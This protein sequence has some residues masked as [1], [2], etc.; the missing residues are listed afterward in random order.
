MIKL[1]GAH[2]AAMEKLKAALVI[3]VF[4]PKVLHDKVE[5]AAEVWKDSS[6]RGKPHSD[7]CSSTTARLRAFLGAIHEAL[8]ST[9]PLLTAPVEAKEALALLVEKVRK[10]KAEELISDDTLR[11]A[12]SRTADQSP[13]GMTLGVLGKRPQPSRSASRARPPLTPGTCRRKHGRSELTVLAVVEDSGGLFVLSDTC[14]SGLRQRP[15]QGVLSFHSFG[16]GAASRT[17]CAVLQLFTTF[18]WRS[19]TCSS[20]ARLFGA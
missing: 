13:Y 1:S 7:G 10:G 15:T 6:E 9:V 11:I 8:S 17:S 18:C 19:P 4:L 12:G 3:L 14:F 16:F 5:A 2:D 20:S